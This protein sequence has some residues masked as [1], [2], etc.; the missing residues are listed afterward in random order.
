MVTASAWHGR[1]EVSEAGKQTSEVNPH[2]SAA[3]QLSLAA[4]LQS[5]RTTVNINT[6]PATMGGASV[7]S[8]EAAEV[9]TAM[10]NQPGWFSREIY[11][12][13]ALE[14]PF[15]AH[16]SKTKVFFNEG[17]GDTDTTLIFDVSAPNE[18]DVLSWALVSE[19]RPGYNPSQW[20]ATKEISYGHR[21][22]TAQ[23]YRDAIRTPHFSK[24]DLA[25]KPKREAQLAQ[26][27]QIMLNWTRG[28]WQ[29]WS[30][31]AFVRSVNCLVLN[32]AWG[33]SAEGVGAY[34]TYATPNTLL[35][36]RFLET[37]KPSVVFTPRGFNSA[38]AAAAARLPE[39]KQLVFIGPNEYQALVEHYQKELVTSFGMAPDETMIPELGF[40]AKPLQS[41]L[42]VIVPYP[43]KFRALAAGETWEDC[44]IPSHI[45]VAADGGAKDGTK[46]IPNPDYF[47]P[48]VALY[49]ETVWCNLDSVEW[50]VPPQAMV[51]GMS[52]GSAQMFPATDY[53]GEFKPFHSPED[54]YQE[55][56]AY[57]ARYMAGMKSLFPQ[58]SRAILTLSAF[59]TAQAYTLT[60][61][62]GVNGQTSLRWSVANAAVNA[63]GNLEMLVAG[64][65]PDT[66]PAGYT[67]YG[68]TRSGR[69]YIVASIVTNASFAGNAKYPAGRRVELTMLPSG[70][71]NE[72]PGDPWSHLE[73][74]PT[75]T[76]TDHTTTTAETFA[77]YFVT[78]TVTGMVGSNSTNLLGASSYTSASTLQ[79]A[80]QTYLDANGGGTASV[81]GGN[82]ASGY[83]WIVK[84]TSPG[85]DADTALTHANSGITFQDGIGSNK[86]LLQK[87][88]LD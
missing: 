33:I 56:V 65:L 16:V 42:F 84:V 46:M 51:S 34:P 60:N 85:G 68:V 25:M 24:I 66:L 14:D 31:M 47:N 70:V 69:R 86:V 1:K 52:N 75:G 74:L 48:A 8:A 72:M 12:S 32:T 79:T 37:I 81:T 73:A 76:P 58:R 3:T 88:N 26:V 38:S 4:K 29:L 28:I 6:L 2:W 41:Y 19:A 83:L 63:S 35:T 71:S 57:Y 44:I 53:S 7:A 80:I 54:P 27:R 20:S 67:L 77:A 62:F 23:L 5:F 82:A 22:V 18:R 78:D 61:Q 10:Q 87:E 59:P 30:R 13:L 17:M 11:Q 36:Y 64:T 21:K 43:R 15:L 45:Q 40:K 49:T 50:L 9:I 55:T 39:D